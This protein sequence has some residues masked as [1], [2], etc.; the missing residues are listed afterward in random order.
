VGGVAA[1][2]L[3][4]E[5]MAAKINLPLFIAPPEFATDNAAMIAAAAYFVRASW[6]EADI[7]PALTL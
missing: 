5:R 2:A 6:D 1:N 3:L 4:R 7:E